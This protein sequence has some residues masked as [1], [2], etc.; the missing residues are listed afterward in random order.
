MY[1]G[2]TRF[3][4]DVFGHFVRESPI[5]HGSI[6]ARRDNQGVLHDMEIE[7]QEFTVFEDKIHLF[8]LHK[9]EKPMKAMASAKSAQTIGDEWT[10]IHLNRETGEKRQSLED[11]MD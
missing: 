3:A 4:T 6:I 5:L 8:C 10:M 1:T 2:E 7:G 11:D 9:T